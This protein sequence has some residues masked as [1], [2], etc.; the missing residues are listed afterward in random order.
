MVLRDFA[1]F[2]GGAF[3]EAAEV[4]ARADAKADQQDSADDR[5]HGFTAGDHHHHRPA[6]LAEGIQR[7]QALQIAC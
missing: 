5:Q 6:E 4:A 7:Q 1:D 3:K 2:A